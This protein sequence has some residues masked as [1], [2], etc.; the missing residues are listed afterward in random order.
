MEKQL[1]TASTFADNCIGYDHL[2]PTKTKL[3]YFILRKIASKDMALDVLMIDGDVLYYA[4]SL[5]KNLGYRDS[6][7]M[8]RIVP[9]DEKETHKV[10]TPGGVQ[11]AL[12]LKELGFFRVLFKTRSD[13]SEAVKDWVF[14][15]VL[16]NFR[17]TGQFTIHQDAKALGVKLDFTDDQWSWLALHPGMVDLVPFAIA[18]Y[19][20]RE[21]SHKL[22]YK[23]AATGVTAKK[24]IDRLKTLGFVPKDVVP[25][26]KQLEARI[27]TAITKQA[28]AV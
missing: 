2:P 10:R 15:E 11:T 17:A 1:Q 6:N 14:D 22:S 20:P 8:H 21:I 16:P 12:F 23:T 24:Q 25:R 3:D 7:G 13:V 5:A 26:K 28:E 9:N 18:G 4:P 27:Q 19:G